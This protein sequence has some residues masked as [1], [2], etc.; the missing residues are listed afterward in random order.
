MM[1]KTIA[2]ILSLILLLSCVPAGAACAEEKEINVVTTI[3]PIYDWVR[4]IVGDDAVHVKID[5]LL[6]NGVD[7]HSYQPSA[8]DIL[9]ISTADVFI[10]VGGESDE[11]VEDVLASAMN[12]DLKAINLVE[13]MGDDIKA[14]E[15]VEG[16]EHEHEHDHE[17]EEGHDHEEEDHDHEHEEEDE[18]DEHVWLSLRCAEK[19]TRV[20]AEVLA[21]IDPDHAEHYQKNAAAYLEKLADL[22]ARY[23]ETVNN[24]AFRTLLFGDRFPFR[25]L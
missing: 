1:K 18:A 23:T 16:M 6:D 3:F 8:Q 4:E 11:W 15:V 13:S 10:Y 19:L 2:V 9:A 24:A 5:L 7:L 14:E 25:Y 21:G 20:I 12:P 22:D 17:D